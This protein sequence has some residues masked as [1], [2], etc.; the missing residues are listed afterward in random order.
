MRVSVVVPTCDRLDA[1]SRC[2]SRLAPGSQSLDAAVYDVTVSDDGKLTRAS[3]ALAGRFP[4]IRWTDGPKRGSAANRNHGA[5]FA[6]GY[7]LAFIDDDCIP[8]ADWL[9]AFAS[10][11]AASSA[12]IFEGRTYA[13]R[14]RHS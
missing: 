10:A 14:P 7:L 1:L 6:K 8:D 11:A 12:A 3:E 2:L 13:E 9:G 4:F 5:V